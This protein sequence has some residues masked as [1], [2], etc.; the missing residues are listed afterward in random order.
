[1]EGK[2]QFLE[3]GGEKYFHVPCL[4]DD[5]D[6]VNATVTWTNEWMKK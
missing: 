5:D 3:A 6:W 4:N 2:D 1:M